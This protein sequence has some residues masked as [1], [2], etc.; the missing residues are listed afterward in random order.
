MRLAVNAFRAPLA[1]G[2]IASV[3]LAA[4]SSAASIK[5]SGP[6][7]RV[8]DPTK[9]AAGYLLLENSGDKEDALVSASSPAY[10]RIELHETV[11]MPAASGS[12]APAASSGM[13]G[14]GGMSMAPAS[15]GVTAG[16]M[17]QMRPVTEIKVP[18]KGSVE[19]KQGSYHLMLMEPTGT[20]KIGDKVEITLTFKSGATLKV[21]ADVKG[22]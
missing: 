10:G 1:A 5:A 21:S 3:L 18:A 22:A 15:P 16:P 11:A 20:I 17:M 2:L 4:C 14:M 8:T 6:W 7:V 13:G 9:T 12:M 19:L